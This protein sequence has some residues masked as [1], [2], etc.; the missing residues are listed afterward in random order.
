MNMPFSIQTKKKLIRSQLLLGL[1]LAANVSL[2]GP[3]N[4]ADNALEITDGVEPNVMILNDDSGSMDW[5]ILATQD[6]GTY[7]ITSPVN[8][9]GFNNVT[10]SYYYTFNDGDNSITNIIATI[11]FQLFY[12]FG[13]L[14]GLP[15]VG[16]IPTQRALDDFNDNTLDLDAAGYT[17]WRGVWRTRNSTYNATY[18]NPLVE[19]EPWSGGDDSGAA[20]T[21][22]DPTN[23][24]V[25]P[26]LSAG[27]SVNLT[28]DQNFET[29]IFRSVVTGF[30]N[31]DNFA[32]R[33]N[34]NQYPA[35]Y[36]IW[37]DTN[38]DT[39]VDENDGRT[40]I[41][42]RTG[43]A[44]TNGATCPSNFTRPGNRTDCGGDG[45]P[46]TTTTCSTTQELQNF[47]N[48]F[49]YYRR[50]ELTAKGAIT[51]VLAEQTSIRVGM[52]TINNV[53]NN[54]I[55]VES[56]NISPFSGSKETLFNRIFETQS[57]GGTPLRQNLQ[58]MGQY[59]A[60]GNN[61]IFGTGNSGPGNAN[62]PVQASPT[63]ECQQNYTILMTDGF[64]NGGNPN[65]GNA[66]GDGNDGGNPLGPFDGASF[67]DTHNNTLADVAMHYYER[68]LHG[69]LQNDVPTTTR[70]RNR[71]N[72]TIAPF[73]DMHQHMSTYTIGFGVSGTRNAN[74]D[75]TTSN[76]AQ[77]N[78]GTVTGWPDPANGNLQRI[79]DLRHA[80]W[81]G[82]GEFLSAANIEQLT[83]SLTSV[84]A[85]IQA[86]VGSASAVAFNTQDLEGGSRV[87]RA[88]FDTTLNTGSLVAQDI[89]ITGVI[90]P[91]PNWYAAEQLDSKISASSDIRSIVTYDADTFSGIPFLWSRIN[92]T[93]KSQLE[94][95]AIA[96]YTAAELGEDRLNY[97][98]GQ[99]VNEGGATPSGEF[100]TR[101]TTAGKLGDI[102][103]S[104]PVFIGEPPFSSRDQAPYPVT[105]GNSYSEFVTARSSR[106]EVV[107]VG[108]NAGMFHGFD[109]GTGEEV[110]AFVPNSIFA[111]LSEL[112]DPN[113]A[114]RYFVD[115]T[116]SV[117][118]VYMTPSSG[119]NNGIAS[120]N[121]VAV[122]GL[123][124][125]GPGY[126]ALN[127]TD[128]ADLETEAG[129]ASNV[130]WEFTQADDIGTGPTGNNLNLGAHIREPIVA[131]SN[132]DGPGGEKRWVAIFGNGYNSASTDG[133]AELYILFLDG[134]LDGTWTRGS[135]FVKLTTGNGKAESSDG[136]TPNGLGSV[137]A[138]DIDANG[139]VDVVYAGDYQGNLYRFN[140]SSSTV[141]GLTNP[142]NRPVQTLF[143]ASYNDGGTPQPIT[144]RPIVIKHPSLAGYIV[145]IGT[146]SYFTVEDT[147]S[148]GIQSIYGLWDDFVDPS[149]NMVPVNYSRLQEQ[150]F[151]SSTIVAGFTTRTLS[152]TSFDYGTTGGDKQGWV[153]DLDVINGG[154]IEF[155][156][157]RA[158]RNFL[159]RGSFVFVNTV[160]PKSSSAC[161][162]EPG[163]F[164]LAF[165]PVTGGSGTNIVFDLNNDGIFDADD[166]IG[167]AEGAANVVSGLRSDK[168]TLTDSSTIGN[169]LVSQGSDKSL[170][171]VGFNRLPDT[172][173]TGRH[174]WREIEN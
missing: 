75:N 150:V 144:N 65:V 70:D 56:L 62:C 27:N 112:T 19:Y 78:G 86:G 95:P 33:I 137:R 93:Q 110:F 167:G 121:T 168:S 35:R 16:T 142:S 61:N 103:H 105:T 136:T 87:F 124:V 152:N 55:M 43:G 92:N 71:Y 8:L 67:A 59:F 161:T 66:D 156:G 22:S 44:C 57:A 20:Y 14:G 38:G 133:D 58:A 164:T 49:T 163:S 115:M 141:G 166:N 143:T 130:M 165:D 63:G 26:Y 131:M 122:G 134:G 90:D 7:R 157:E 37:T 117:N 12:N 132:I 153:I 146:G 30:N 39:I 17:N 101:P 77:F 6:Q 88:F 82:R 155:P 145:I 148:T 128:P 123:G 109:A 53:A 89:S 46:L 127:L 79:D 9:N 5:T 25:D 84:F 85:D 149:D 118:D 52:A 106:R 147:T 119:T 172:D 91:D 29:Y 81:N 36:Y 24:P 10:M 3:L 69:S 73:E 40:L 160:I 64:W 140:L 174:S 114:H 60:C 41:Q 18:Y 94:L 139:T 171:D 31:S 1:L 11:P 23:A 47:A 120:W 102:V 100:R 2:A 45:D 99:T 83:D 80:A 125:G 74:P 159:L 113:Y 116:A 42:I 138:I 151:T 13:V 129:A 97:L 4:I 126:F 28:A 96:G 32:H 173:N 108:A 50:R 135:D 21:N 104:T 48:W 76:P 169:R 162:V 15:N 111:S 72:G 170:F 98:R 158:V 34:D 154:G 51:K 107:Y 68:D 54:R